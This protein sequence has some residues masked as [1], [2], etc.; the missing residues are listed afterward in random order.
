MGTPKYLVGQN[1]EKAWSANIFPFRVDAKGSVQ[2][3]LRFPGQVQDAESG[4][5]YNNAREYVPALGR[6][7]Q[8][9]P[10]GLGSGSLNNYIYAGNNPVRWTDPS[11]KFIP[12]IFAV[13]EIAGPIVARIVITRLAPFIIRSVMVGYKTLKAADTIAKATQ[14][15]KV[16]Q[17]C[18]VGASAQARGRTSER[19]VLG[20]MN[21]SKNTKKVNTREGNSI[22]DALTDWQSVEIKDTANISLTKQLRIQTE[23]ARASGRQP[24]LFTGEKTCISGPCINAF[25]RENIIRRPDLGPK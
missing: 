22:P 18:P 10:L 20:E 6:Y 2:Q 23:A 16:K 25:G 8:P 17:I 13:G 24:V 9:D 15:D 7:L 12:L 19:R 3:D 21:L 1:K 5:V 11:G 14:A 4:L